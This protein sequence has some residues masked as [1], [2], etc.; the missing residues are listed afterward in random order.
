MI[1]G[2]IM[3][4]GSCMMLLDKQGAMIKVPREPRKPFSFKNKDNEL[5]E[6]YIDARIGNYV[7][8]DM[9]QIEYLEKIQDMEN[10]EHQFEGY[11]RMSFDRA[12]SISRGG[13]GIVLV[14]PKNIVHPHAI[15][16]E[17]ACTNNEEEYEA[18]IQGMILAQEMK[19]KH[20]IVIG[21]SELVINQV[22]QR[23][24]NKKE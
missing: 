8:L 14:N 1:G 18:L 22:T 5:M 21:D 12:F 11:W 23:Y 2:Y 13:L 17:F 7:I 24:K 16:L 6:D 19:I 9:E 10:Q 3:N 20:I 15:R 4:D